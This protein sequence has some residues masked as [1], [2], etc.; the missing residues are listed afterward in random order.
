MR[1]PGERPEATFVALVGD[2]EVVGYA[3]FSFTEAQPTTAHHD[4]TAVK[5]AWR[6]RG[7]GR[8][9][10]ARQIVWAKENGYAE[11][12]ARNE[13]ATSSSDA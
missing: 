5:R 11:L 7:I 13:R 4:P 2:D 10:K 1:G 9:L 6:G 8:A 3:K 12:R